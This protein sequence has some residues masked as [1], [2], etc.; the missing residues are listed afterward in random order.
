MSSVRIAEG[1]NK[2]W[3][4]EILA[5]VRFHAVSFSRLGEWDSI[6]AGARCP[7]EKD[8]GSIVTR[9]VCDAGSSTCAFSFHEMKRDWLCGAS[10]LSV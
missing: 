4:S 10:Q 2:D 3:D 7:A 5:A 1:A 6:H 9:L 8:V